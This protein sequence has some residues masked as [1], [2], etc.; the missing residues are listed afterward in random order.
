LQEEFILPSAYETWFIT[1]ALLKEDLDFIQA[2]DKYPNFNQ[3]FRFSPEVFIF[4]FSFAIYFIHPFF[5]HSVCTSFVVLSFHGIPFATD[6]Y[7][8]F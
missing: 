5:V 8:S 2:I 3:N 1:D 6:K 7:S 4:V